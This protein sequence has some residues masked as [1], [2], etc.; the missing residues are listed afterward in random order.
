MARNRRYHPGDWTIWIF[1]ET[2][3]TEWDVV[4]I[5]MAICIPQVLHVSS[6]SQTGITYTAKMTLSLL[7]YQWCLGRAPFLCLPSPFYPVLWNPYPKEQTGLNF[8]LCLFASQKP[9]CLTA[10]SMAYSFSHGP[11][12]MNRYQSCTQPS[13]AETCPFQ[14]II[15]FFTLQ[16]WFFRKFCLQNIFLILFLNILIDFGEEER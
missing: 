6:L 16:L 3:Q 11:P 5:S 10:L 15:F 9:S 7:P 4:G 14:T 12:S 1:A 13:P 2:L 8:T